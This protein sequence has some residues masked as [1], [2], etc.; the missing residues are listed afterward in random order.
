MHAKSPVVCEQIIS[1]HIDFGFV[2][3]PVRHPDLVIRKLATDEVGFWSVTGTKSEVVIYNPD[4]IQS[5]TLLRKAAPL[6][7]NAITSESLE[8]I[9]TIARSGMGMAILPTRVART[10]APELNRITEFPVYPDQGNILL[11]TRSSAFSRGH[12]GPRSHQETQTVKL[13]RADDC[14]LVGGFKLV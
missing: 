8:V 1:G 6:I 3:N 4:L 10:I 9:S 11:P 5:Q 13:V 7:V 14:Q 2:V 12:S